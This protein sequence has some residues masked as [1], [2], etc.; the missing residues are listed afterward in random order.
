MFDW[1][2]GRFMAALTKGEGRQRQRLR[3]WWEATD[4][5]GGVEK[6]VIGSRVGGCEILARWVF[7]AER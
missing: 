4:S 3:L 6:R 5:G 7:L 1:D 2:Q